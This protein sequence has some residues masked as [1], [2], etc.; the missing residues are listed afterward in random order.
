MGLGACAAGQDGIG[1]CC[2][3]SPKIPSKPPNLR[4]RS[5]WL[6]ELRGDCRIGICGCNSWP[7]NVASPRNSG[8]WPSPISTMFPQIYSISLCPRFNFTG[9]VKVFR[10]R[11]LNII[12]EKQ[13]FSVDNYVVKLHLRLVIQVSLSKLFINHIA[14]AA[15][16]KYGRNMSI[17]GLMRRAKSR[18]S[19][20]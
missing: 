9:L 5:N 8:W 2:R 12:P 17:W 1:F 7:I 16:R 4:A 18:C 11:K 6:V 20:N 19:T 3:N 14:F 15:N 13:I 10:Q